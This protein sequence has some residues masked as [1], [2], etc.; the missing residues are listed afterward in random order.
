MSVLNSK[1]NEENLPRLKRN[2]QIGRGLTTY[3]GGSGDGKEFSD[4][5]FQKNKSENLSRQVSCY[6]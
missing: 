2:S 1:S 5:K 4:F 3:N 6:A